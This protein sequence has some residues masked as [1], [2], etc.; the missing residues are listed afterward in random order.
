MNLVCLQ[1]KSNSADRKKN[2]EGFDAK[3]KSIG[4]KAV[5]FLHSSPIPVSLS[6]AAIKPFSHLCKDDA[7]CFLA[8]HALI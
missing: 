5:Q 8:T 4:T 2:S 1:W 3:W 6:I 7:S